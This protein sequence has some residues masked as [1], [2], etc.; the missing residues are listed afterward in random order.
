MSDSQLMFNGAP[1]AF[2]EEDRPPKVYL[3]P[4]RPMSPGLLRACAALFGPQF[5]EATRGFQDEY[6][7]AWYYGA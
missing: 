4:L 7:M 3:L 2:D 6:E 5:V 1:V